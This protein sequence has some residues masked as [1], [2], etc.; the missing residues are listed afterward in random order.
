MLIFGLPD[1]SSNDRMVMLSLMYL[2]WGNEE[3]LQVSMRDLAK[4]N[5][6]SPSVLCDSAK[7]KQEKQ[8][9]IEQGK[10][11]EGSLTRLSNL[12]YITVVEEG[13]K[14]Y[15]TVHL[16]KI[17]D[18]NAEFKK[19]HGVPNSNTI[20]SKGVLKSN[21][22]IPFHVLKSN[23]TVL[24]SNASDVQDSSTSGLND[25]LRTNKNLVKEREKDSV[26]PTLTPESPMS[27]Q[28]SASSSLSSQQ[29]VSEETK[30]TDVDYALFDRL[31]HE[32]GYAATFK[33]PRNEKNN[34]ALQELRS[35]GATAEQ[36][37]FVFN[38]IWE[39]KDPFWIQHRGKPSTVA[40][41]FTARVWKMNQ[42]AVKRRTVSGFA[43]WT[44]DKSMGVVQPVEPTPERQE[45]PK[46]PTLPAGYTRLKRDTPAR[47]RTLQGRLEAQQ[48]GKATS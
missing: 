16:Q 47:A 27:S 33:V 29:S 5:H 37:A 46:E 40:S 45:K 42:P 12:G 31:C 41:Q 28:S 4:F 36:V 3:P 48:D 23:T 13:G 24:N 32:K 15:I 25:P 1:L 20:K 39:D 26:A 19:Q 21:N 11:R 34:A 44:L 43:N 35:Q 14:T 38:D 30:P 18:A 7:N 2:T 8:K 6:I 10:F 22:E 17:W 9:Q